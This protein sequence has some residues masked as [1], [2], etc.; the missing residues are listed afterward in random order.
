M[1]LVAAKPDDPEQGSQVLEFRGVM[2]CEDV[3]GRVLIAADDTGEFE[4]LAVPA[5]AGV[6]AHG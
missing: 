6:P 3:F 4:G 5:R 2:V 1:E